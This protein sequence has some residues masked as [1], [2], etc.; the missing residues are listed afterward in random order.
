[1]V[2]QW[3]YLTRF[4]EAE[5]T[6]EVKEYLKQNFAVK[7]PPRFTPESMIPELNELGAQGWELVQMQ[8][9]AK[10]G[11]KG[12]V[13]F[14]G[15]IPKWSNVYFCVFKRRKPVPAQPPAPPPAYAAT[16][17]PVQQQVPQPAPYQAPPPAQPAGQPPQYTSPH[18]TSDA[19]EYE[20]TQLGEPT[21]SPAQRLGGLLEQDRAGGQRPSQG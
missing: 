10:V 20:S 5:V 4:L 14:S 17:P 9:V 15:E 8:P 18:A 11:S 7:R 16:P 12:N 2:E 13:F 21:A 19:A 1:M 6:K 3:E